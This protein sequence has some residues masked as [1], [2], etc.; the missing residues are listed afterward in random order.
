MRT[1]FHHRKTELPPSLFELWWTGGLGDPR[2][3][4]SL[5]LRLTLV[6]FVLVIVIG[7]RKRFARGSGLLH[8]HWAAPG[9]GGDD[10]RLPTFDARSLIAEY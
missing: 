8:W 4:A 6:P 2:H 5:D 7:G 10:S 9:W 1:N 3:V